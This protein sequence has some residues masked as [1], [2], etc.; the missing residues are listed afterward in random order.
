MR[1]LAIALLG[2]VL[3]HGTA[4]A[5]T[6]AE[7]EKILAAFKQRV[8]DLTVLNQ[9]TDPVPAIFTLP[10]AT[11]FRQVIAK[12]LDEPAYAPQLVGAGTALPLA[13]HPAV[14]EP[15][16]A[17]QLHEFPALLARALPTLPPALE[18]RLIGDDLVLREVRDD[19]IVAVLRNAVGGAATTRR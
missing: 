15:F 4:F 9:C 18:Y 13:H 6:P 14:L 1:T 19:V 16:P 11:V 10:V 12:A 17:T 5:Q 8:A 3:V 7:Q 2:I